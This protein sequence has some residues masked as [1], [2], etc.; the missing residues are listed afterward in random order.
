[1]AAYAAVWKVLITYDLNWQLEGKEPDKQWSA[2]FLRELNACNAEH[3]VFFSQAVYAR[4]VEYR[5]CLVGI[6]ERARSSGQVSLD[7]VQRLATLAAGSPD[8]P[9]LATA[10]KDDLGSYIRI[11]LQVGTS[12][13]GS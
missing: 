6:A 3:G 11:H 4:F 12:P 1:M 10:L 13:A 2:D 7:D 5:G 9:G 8:S